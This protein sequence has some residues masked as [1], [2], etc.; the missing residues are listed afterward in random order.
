MVKVLFIYIIIISVSLISCTPKLSKLEAFPNMYKESPVTILVLP[1]LNESTAAEA[2]D[3]YTTTIAEPLAET[4]FYIFPIEV[5][6]QILQE[7]GLYEIGSMEN[8]P[9]DKFLNY[10]GTDAVLFTRI[11][12][13]NT[14]YYVIGGNVTVTIDFKLVSTK[15][16]ETLWKNKRTITVDTSGDSGNSGGLAGLL[17][18]VASTAIKTAATDYVPQAKNVNIQALKSMPFGKYHRQYN[19]DQNSKVVDKDIVESEEK[20]N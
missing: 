6:N 18:L 16:G 5:I 7:Q 9:L 20:R 14:S 12:E 17:V 8:M 1:P 15:T 2:T 3:Y 19:Q 4:G 10:F 13:W 11:I